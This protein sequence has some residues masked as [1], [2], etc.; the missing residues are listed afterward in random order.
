MFFPHSFCCC[1]FADFT[2]RWFDAFC[3]FFTTC[4]MSSIKN[5]SVLATGLAENLTQ[6][7][8]PQPS[9]IQHVRTRSLKPQISDVFI[10]SPKW[11]YFVI[12]DV[13]VFPLAASLLLRD[14]SHRNARMNQTKPTKSKSRLGALP[15][16][17]KNT[18]VLPVFFKNK[19]CLS[20]ANRIIGE[21]AIRPT[22]NNQ[23][24]TN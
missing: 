13:I 5:L 8:F 15:G 2:W 18:V 22:F 19:S 1:F 23:V 6:V 4:E 20:K 3:Y 10:F 12:F 17:V 21:W 7:V 24:D 9:V 14:L 16:G 11:N